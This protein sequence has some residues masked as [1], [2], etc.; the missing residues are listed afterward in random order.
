MIPS[1]T[2]YNL[3]CMSTMQDVTAERDERYKKTE[4]RKV[5]GREIL[6]ED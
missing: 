3:S 4:K 2:T 1:K 6:E 5:Y